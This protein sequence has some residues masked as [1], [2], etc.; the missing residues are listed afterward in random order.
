[1]PQQVEAATKVFDFAMGI[2]EI[3]DIGLASAIVAIRP[4]SERYSRIVDRLC[5]LGRR[6]IEPG[7]AGTVRQWHGHP[8]RCGRG[9][10]RGI[11]THRP[12]GTG[13]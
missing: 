12:V 4:V 6:R 11:H 8:Q 10:R 7:R 1:M 2:S 9:C 3:Q 13:V 5:E